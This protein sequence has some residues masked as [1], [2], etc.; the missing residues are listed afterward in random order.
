MTPFA[1]KLGV[2]VFL[3]ASC[4]LCRAQVS[5]NAG[6]YA[7]GNRNSPAQNERTK[8]NPTPA[9]LRP[10]NTDT[11]V[12][13]SV[14]M[15][16]RADEYV[17]VFGVAQEGPT[18]AGA[19]TKMD[20]TLAAFRTA[21]RDLGVRDEDSFVDYVTQTKIYAYEVTGDLAK[22]KLVGFEVKKNVSVHFKDKT[23]LDKLT[24]A[25]ASAQIFDLIKMDY[26][27]ANTSAIQNQLRQEAAE[28][29]RTKAARQ[30]VLLGIKLVGPV[31]VVADKPS[32][33]F[34]VDQ[35]DSYAASESESV[36]VEDAKEK[37]TV[38]EA[39]KSRTFYFNPLGA[40]GFDKVI[41]PV[42]TE[43][44]VQFT[45]YLKVRYEAAKTA[46]R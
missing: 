18:L 30:G 44:V 38:Q 35:Y 13:A 27:V 32:I 12:E 29:V 31:Q 22:E 10:D 26:V 21:L 28:I 37:F 7:S 41:N 39:R 1:Q 45:M 33:Y 5:G 9:E 8:R 46:R 14:L 15:N 25:A 6:A 42:V 17:A 24:L 34:P 43:P 3:L 36:R 2:V 11:F 40:D 16:M 23:L 20:A 4:S 19:N